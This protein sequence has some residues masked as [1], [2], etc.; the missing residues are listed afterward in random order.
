MNNMNSSKWKRSGSSIIWDAE[1]LTPF[2]KNGDFISLREALSWLPNLPEEPPV[3]ST[4]VVIS[5][6]QDCLEL[7]GDKDNALD[8]LRKEILTFI[9]I[10]Q[11]KWSNKG[12]VFAMSASEKNFNVND[13]DNLIYFNGDIPISF[14]IW[15]GTAKDNTA[16]FRLC[17]KDGT[18]DIACGYH[19]VRI[20]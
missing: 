5:G 8:F 17:K 9:Q 4:T 12:I 14:G 19:C 10:A 1:F 15:N 2:I 20:S 18:N 16:V 13:L 3:N 6:M 7:I 11:D